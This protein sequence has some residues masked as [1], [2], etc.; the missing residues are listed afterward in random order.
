MENLSFKYGN[1]SDIPDSPKSGTVY[2]SRDG[3]DRHSLRGYLINW[4]L[5][6]CSS[7][8]LVSF[9]YAS[10]ANTLFSPIFYLGLPL[11]IAIPFLITFIVLSLPT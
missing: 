8:G 7:I 4:M 2:F 6:V 10:Y 11:F 9:L 5:I 3:N 1:L